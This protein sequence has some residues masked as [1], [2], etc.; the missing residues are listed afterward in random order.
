MSI[1]YAVLIFIPLEL[2]LNIYRVSRLINWEIDTVIIWVSVVII[3]VVVIGT[4]LL[5]YLTKRW[6]EERK[7]NF[8]TV[9]LWV[10]Y[11]GF[12]IYIFANLFPVTYGGDWPSPVIGLF[13]IGGLIVY[14]IYI[15]MINF[16]GMSDSKID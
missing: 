4:I 9:L 2:M 10:P 13:A 11:F 5:L 16:I 3:I 1:L 7:A 8:W 12:F 15:L 14:P 6:L